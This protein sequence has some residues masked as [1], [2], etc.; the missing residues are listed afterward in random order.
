MFARWLSLQPLAVRRSAHATSRYIETLKERLAPSEDHSTAAATLV[1]LRDDDST[2]SAP[3]SKRHKASEAEDEVADEGESDEEGEPDEGDEPYEEGDELSEFGEEG[4]PDEGD[5]PDE[6]GD[7]LSEF[8]E[9]GEPD[10]GDEPYEEGETETDDPSESGEEVGEG[11]HGETSAAGPPSPEGVPEALWRFGR[12]GSNHPTK[13]GHYCMQEMAGDTHVL[14][15]SKDGRQFEVLANFKG[16]DVG[17]VVRA[18]LQSLKARL[19]RQNKRRDVAKK[20][21]AGMGEVGA[22]LSQIARDAQA[23]KRMLERKL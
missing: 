2:E 6:E 13:L 17:G 22:A 1:R 18:A 21:E 15:M 3:P 12:D 16:K 5:E 19:L 23:A 10:E 9:E 7:E 14:F 11:G 8:G 20:T 4:D